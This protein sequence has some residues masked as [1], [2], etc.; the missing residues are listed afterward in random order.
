MIGTEE[1]DDS[2]DD[3]LDGDDPDDDLLNDDEPEEDYDGEDSIA[4]DDE[5][6]LG[7]DMDEDEND[8]DDDLARASSQADFA[9]DKIDRETTDAEIS[10]EEISLLENS[11]PVERDSD[12][13]S[14]NRSKLDETDFDGETLNEISSTQNVDGNDL[15]V[16]GTEMDDDDEA[17]GEE[18]EENNLY[19]VADTE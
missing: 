12:T 18:D 17:I 5:G 8:M 9:G 4:E 16:P 2:D 15:D 3:D 11:G 14:L 1:E 13:D 7:D 6:D 19:S 10:A